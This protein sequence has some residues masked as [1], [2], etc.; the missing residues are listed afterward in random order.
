[1]SDAHIL[2]RIRDAEKKTAHSNI[3]KV[4]RALHEVSREES[5]SLADLVV[6]SFLVTPDEAEQLERMFDTILD[7]A[8]KVGQEVRSC[9]P[10][11]ERSGVWG[12]ISKLAQYRH[13][14]YWV[15]VWPDGYS[16]MW[17]VDAKNGY[18]FRKCK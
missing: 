4:R 7:R 16:D 12:K 8:K 9:H 15:V 14:M 11:A 13:W 17:P 6:P 3:A 18:E 2:V 10:D 1:M 5:I